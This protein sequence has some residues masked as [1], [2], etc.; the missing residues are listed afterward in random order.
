MSGYQEEHVIR[1]PFCREPMT[2]FV[3]PSVDDATYT[4]DCQICCRPILMTVT[5]GDPEERAVVF[6]ERE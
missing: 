4:E 6:V 2:I 5:R 3:D 1:C